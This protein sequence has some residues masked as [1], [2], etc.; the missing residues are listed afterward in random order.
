M[1]TKIFILTAVLIFAFAGFGR[2]EIV[3][4]DL[5]SLGMPTTFNPASP[6]HWWQT[7]FDLG[8]TFTQISHVYI[9]WSGEI[10]GGLGIY[11]PGQQPFPIDVGVYAS[12][13]FNPDLRRTEIWGGAESYPSPYTFDQQNEFTLEG[14]T[15]WSDLLDGKA[16]ITIGYTAFNFTEGGY[17]QY[18]SVALNAATL[19]VDGIVTPE[20]ASVLLFTA[21]MGVLRFTHLF[22]RHKL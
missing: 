2:A 15:T 1:R 12:F 7:N 3:T 13:G 22:S 10:T 6:P 20:P 17:T 8:V 4:L 14:T 5:F 19:V 9:N 21:G 16:K 18:G 11:Q